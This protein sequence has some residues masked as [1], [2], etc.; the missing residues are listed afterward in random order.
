MTTKR[1]SV[2]RKLE[3]TAETLEECDRSFFSSVLFQI[4]RDFWDNEHNTED[5][6]YIKYRVFF[7]HLHGLALS[8]IHKDRKVNAEDTFGIF[9]KKKERKLAEAYW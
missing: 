9:C 3:T 4:L 1:E 8:N 5:F 7:T 6:F 2:V